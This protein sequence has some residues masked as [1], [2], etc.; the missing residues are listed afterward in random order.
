MQETQETWVQFLGQEDPPEEEMETHTNILAWK[1]PWT[2]SLMGY[3]PCGH[4]ELDTTKHSTEL[5]CH[6]SQQWQLRI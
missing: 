5:G 3:S 2:E 1:F 6:L 4:K